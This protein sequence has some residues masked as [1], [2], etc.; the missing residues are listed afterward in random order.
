MFLLLLIAFCDYC[1]EGQKM[2][3]QMTTDGTNITVLW[4]IANSVGYA[5]VG[6]GTSMTNADMVVVWRNSNRVILSPRYSTGESLPEYVKTKSYASQ[7]SLNS[8]ND[9]NFWFVKF[10]RPLK[11]SDGLMTPL[12]SGENQIIWAAGDAPDSADP[13]TTFDQHSS[14]GSF[15]FNAATGSSGVSLIVTLHGYGL[16]IF[17]LI[18]TPISIMLARYFKHI[19]HKWFIAHVGVQ[20]LTVL[21]TIVLGL[22]M[23]NKYSWGFKTLH[24]IIGIVIIVI[25]TLQLVSGAVIHFSYDPSRSSI[26]ARD[27]LHGV[28]GFLLWFASIY[29]MVSGLK[30]NDST[31]LYIFS[32]IAG[33]MFMSLLVLQVR[34][35]KSWK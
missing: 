7:Y 12:I 13:S 27:R 21:A 31:R 33:V 4:K 28:V 22:L 29:Q 9:P 34:K 14:Q 5:G 8:A 15:V 2:C 18:L 1:V 17:W 30:G 26:P 3:F 11:P 10:T 6:F 20:I 32:A 19:G 25:G 35:S 23:E 16:L 24:E